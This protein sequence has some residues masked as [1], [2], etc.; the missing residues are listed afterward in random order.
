MRKFTKYPSSYVRADVNADSE[1]FSIT[2]LL[3]AVGDGFEQAWESMLERRE[4]DNSEYEDALVDFRNFFSA[5]DSFTEEQKHTVFAM[6]YELEDGFTKSMGSFSD[7]PGYESDR[8]FWR[9]LD[10]I[11]KYLDA[12]SPMLDRKRQLFRL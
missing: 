10:K 7:T 6:L 11:G 8:A 3:D 4:F 12:D 1:R 5:S 9:A 2:A